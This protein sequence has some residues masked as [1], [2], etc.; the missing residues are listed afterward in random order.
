MLALSDTA[1]VILLVLGVVFVV[2]AGVALFL[3]SRVTRE[4]APDIPPAMEP[5]PSD[6]ALE[7]PLLQKL[8]GWGVVLVAFF[9][10]WLPYNWLIEPST[11]LEQE[12]ALR[13][14]AIERGRRSVEL[15][16]EENQLG[17]GCVRCHG[18]ELRGGVIPVGTGWAYPPDLTTIC[19]GPST[20]HPLH[21]VGHRHPGHDR[22]G[23]RQHAVVEHPVSGRAR[24]PA[25]QRHRELPGAHELGERPVRG[26]H[27]H[28]P[29]RGQGGQLAVG[30]A[31]RDQRR[32]GV[33]RPRPEPTGATGATA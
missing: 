8:Q 20:G 16:S 18:P 15:F 26:Q 9:V 24:R 31:G 19:G 6:P 33:D 1:G 7:T 25:D 32:H 28:Q 17:V 14:Q 5:G 12:E 10:V 21:Q 27:L 11:N 3:R 23:A 29:R 2:A 4:P 30:L 13:T 22:T